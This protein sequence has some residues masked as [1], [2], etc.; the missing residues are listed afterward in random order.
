MST[1]LGG[2]HPGGTRQL[3]L[4]IIKYTVG[5]QKNL[6]NP[7]PHCDWLVDDDAQTQKT[8]FFNDHY[9]F[10]RITE[11]N[12][13]LKESPAIAIAKQIIDTKV[14]ENCFF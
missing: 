6:S 12:S 5:I 2:N 10:N 7:S 11:Y 14:G 8:L 9:N 13:Y 4:L 3:S 1:F